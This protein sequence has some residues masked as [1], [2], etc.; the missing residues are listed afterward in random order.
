MYPSRRNARPILTTAS[1]VIMAALALTAC[2]SG[3]PKS[4]ATP[5]SGAT[6]SA[7]TN[8]AAGSG[9][10]VSA[11]TGALGTYLTDAS[12]RTLY[13]F[14]TDTSGTSTCSGS[15]A[16]FWPPFTST[17][18]P[19]ATGQAQSGMLGTTTR[20][21]GTTQVTYDGHPLYHFKLDAAAGDT[22]G[23]G[24]NAFGGL[25]WVVAPA[26][27]PITSAGG[28]SPSGTASGSY[29]PTSRY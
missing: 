27:T 16:Q 23:Q 17:G 12:G 8:A 6:T 14:A 4:A 28:S 18:M 19:K 25:W 7:S 5:P 2:A 1:A 29:S 11:K 9:A 24:Q 15:C 10:T 21:D 20:P 22:K 26:G 13:S 3:K